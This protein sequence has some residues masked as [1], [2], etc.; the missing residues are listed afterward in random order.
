MRIICDK[1]PISQ[2]ADIRRHLVDEESR[3]IFDARVRYS[4]DQD[5]TRFYDSLFA[6][7]YEYSF[8]RLDEICDNFPETDTLIIFG[9]GKDGVYTCK[10]LEQSK[11]RN[12]NIMFC[13]GRRT[14]TNTIRGKKVISLCELL[15]EYRNSV[16]IISSRKYAS[17]IY[18][19]L[20]DNGFPM[21]KV[22]QNGVYGVPC[23]NAYFDFFHPMDHEVFLDAGAMDGKTSYLF[24][25]WCRGTY[26]KIFAIEVNPNQLQICRQNAERWG[27]KNFQLIDQ[28]VWS[29]K[30]TLR[31][32]S[33]GAAGVHIDQEGD[34]NIEVDRIDNIV[35]GERVTFIKM[36]IEGSELEALIGAEETIRKWT[37]RLAICVYHRPEDIIDIP[38]YIHQVCPEYKFALRH[39]TNSWGDTVLYAWK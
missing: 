38:T 7:G 4:I 5:E 14:V 37:P 33:D 18:A 28:G 31:L 9:T 8:A 23:G 17:A 10:T 22:L 2:L 24:G 36:D 34:C 27:L 12:Y 16:V 15:T 32:N 39:Y 21:T 35:G 13:N 19:Q 26:D 1:D 3:K 29:S 11:Y 25:Q 6:L 30:T 20:V